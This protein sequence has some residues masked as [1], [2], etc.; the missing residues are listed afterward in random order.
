MRWLVPMLLLVAALNPASAYAIAPQLILSGTNTSYTLGN[1]ARYY[2]DTSNALTLPQ[3]LDSTIQAKLKKTKKGYFILGLTD[4][5]YWFEIN[6]TSKTEQTW[7]FS[8][9]YATNSNMQLYLLEENKPVESAI[10]IDNSYW[11]TSRHYTVPLPLEANKNYRL[12]IRADTP[13]PDKFAFVI[14]DQAAKHAFENI[15]NRWLGLFYGGFITLVLYNGFLAFSTRSRTYGY[16]ILYLI[17]MGYYLFIMDG[18]GLKYLHPVSPHWMD[19]TFYYSTICVIAFFGCQFSRYFLKTFFHDKETDRIIKTVMFIAAVLLLLTLT[20]G[21]VAPLNYAVMILTAGYAVLLVAVAVKSLLAGNR[22]ARFFS[23]AWISPVLGILYSDLMFIGVNHY[24]DIGFNA[25]HIASLAEAILLS[26]ALADRINILRHQRSRAV[27]IANEKLEISNRTL[28]KANQLKDSF[29]G[30]I[31]HELR[32]PMNGIIGTVALL[33]N[34][35]LNSDQKEC[36]HTLDDASAQMLMMVE[37]ILLFSELQSDRVEKRDASLN[38]EKL[39]LEIQQLWTERFEKKDISFSIQIEPLATKEILIDGNKLHYIIHELLSNA[40]K[41]THNGRVQLTISQSAADTNPQF[42]LEIIDTGIGIPEA[43]LSTIQKS[44][45]QVQQSYNRQYG[46]LGI[47]LAITKELVSILN[48]EWK[49]EPNHPQGTRVVIHLPYKPPQ[50]N[51]ANTNGTDTAVSLNAAHQPSENNPTGIEAHLNARILIAEDNQ[52]N[53]LVMKK[54]LASLGHT[55]CVA[56]NGEEAF[57][58]A[59]NERFKLI[60]MDCQ[61]PVMDGFATTLAIREQVN[62]NQDTPI[63]AVTANATEADQKHCLEVGMNA[64][65]KKP[66]RPSDLDQ[67]IRAWC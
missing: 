18:F 38:V 14:E 29:L 47:G 13:G 26:M 51:A 46:G 19:A 30:T 12:I 36:V 35:S 17:S 63:I 55:Y 7:L 43:Q 3:F 10:A 65:L 11:V 22:L 24:S 20:F 37:R 56:N 34:G 48:G 58:C 6:L 15:D 9:R 59:Q 33:K 57:K 27:I 32:T 39:C 1:Y 62:L 4:F 66:V 23:I 41:F 54:I 61:M 8:L 60:F 67:I 42:C 5:S 16:Y 52:V 44:F 45:H 25:V 49:I 31:S 2:Q 21:A 64:Y 28:E 40:E 53:Q 50:I